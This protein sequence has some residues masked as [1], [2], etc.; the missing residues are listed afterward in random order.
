MCLISRLIGV[1]QVCNAV[2]S[3][4]N[5]LC[6]QAFNI[7]FSFLL[8]LFVF[9]FYPYLQRYLQPHQKGVICWNIGTRVVDMHQFRLHVLQINFSLACIPLY[10]TFPHRSYKDS[11]IS[12]PGQPWTSSTRGIVRNR[13]N[14]YTYMLHITICGLSISYNDCVVSPPCSI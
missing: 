8:Q 11:D 5:L 9:N 6:C 2:S 7:F 10:F 12:C 4:I 13:H 1:H 3:R 14:S